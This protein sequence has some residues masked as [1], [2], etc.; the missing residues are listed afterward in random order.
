MRRF[1]L[2]LL[3]SVL[4]LSGI[5]LIQAAR[6]ASD[7]TWLSE[8]WNSVKEFSIDQKDKAVADGQKAMDRFDMQMEEMDA[9][10][11]KDSTA[12]SQGWD[13]TKAQ[14]GELR[15][16]AQTKLDQLGPATKDSWESVKQEFGDA[17]QKLE[18]AYNKARN[19]LG[20]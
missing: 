3:M 17:V 6:A 18:D 16:N 15:D 9:Q 20:S 7:E 11:S 8:T 4:V 14:L 10:A 19:D 2:P 13:K 12:M 5:S 1:A